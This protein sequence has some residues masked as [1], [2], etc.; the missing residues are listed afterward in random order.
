[1]STAM[2][3]RPPNSIRSGWGGGAGPFVPWEPAGAYPAVDEGEVDGKAAQRSGRHV[4]DLVAD[5]VSGDFVRCRKAA[6]DVL[7]GQRR[8]VVLVRLAL[9]ERDAEVGVPP[10]HADDVLPDLRPAAGVY[11]GVGVRHRL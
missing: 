8:P 6:V 3:S 2:T 9:G 4:E 7:D 10:G 1:M 11:V 5:V